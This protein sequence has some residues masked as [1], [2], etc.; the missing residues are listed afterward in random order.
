M[1]VSKHISLI[2]LCCCHTKYQGLIYRNGTARSRSEEACLKSLATTPSD[3]P[4]VEPPDPM[5]TASEIRVD[6]NFSDAKPGVVVNAT[7]GNGTM[8]V[9]SL[10]SCMQVRIHAELGAIFKT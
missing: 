9:D 6:G 8:H 7:L 5:L 1:C 3:Q 4:C 10:E 2:Q